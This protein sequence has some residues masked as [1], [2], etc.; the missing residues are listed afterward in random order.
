MNMI[1]IIILSIVILL[2]ILFI[3]IMYFGIKYIRSRHYALI[4]QQENN[5]DVYVRFL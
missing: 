1:S 5:D 4:P 3:I 2:L